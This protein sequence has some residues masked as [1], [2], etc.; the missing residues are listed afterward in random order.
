MPK[1]EK[2][3]TRS[4]KR[5]CFTLT[6]VSVTQNAFHAVVCFFEASQCWKRLS[7]F[8]YAVCG[9]TLDP[10]IPALPPSSPLT[11]S[12]APWPPLFLPSW[13]HPQ[14]INDNL[15]CSLAAIW[16]R[17][18]KAVIGRNSTVSL[19]PAVSFAQLTS[20]YWGK[21]H[22]R[23]LRLKTLWRRKN[24]QP[25]FCATNSTILKK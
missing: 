7:L 15:H 25:T 3:R 19:F 24:S 2:L 6:K 21:R 8:L 18:I 20:S 13:Q 22:Q 11:T 16:E 5:L 12:S 4:A 17:S 10:F 1:K 14:V 9:T 23:E